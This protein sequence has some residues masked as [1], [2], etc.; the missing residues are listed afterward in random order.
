MPTYQWALYK[1]SHRSVDSTMRRRNRDHLQT[2]LRQRAS[3]RPVRALVLLVAATI[4]VACGDNVARDADPVPFRETTFAKTITLP[5]PSRATIATLDPSQL[6]CPKES[7]CLTG[8]RLLAITPDAVSA[9]GDN[10]RPILIA[11]VRPEIATSVPDSSTTRGAGVIRPAR[12]A[13]A[14]VIDWSSMR[15]IVLSAA[16][17]ADT[18]AL[19]LTPELLDVRARSDA[20]VA[21]TQGLA[22]SVYDVVPVSIQLWSGT[23][24]RALPKPIK[25]WAFAQ[26][27]GTTG[28]RPTAPLFRTAP[29]WDVSI[30]GRMAYTAGIDFD[31]G[32]FDANG[33]PLLRLIRDVERSP[34]SDS[35]VE[36]VV[37][38]TRQLIAA[39]PAL[40]RES[41]TAQLADA[42]RR[43]AA[44][45]PAV[46]TLRMLPDGTLW[47]RGA[48]APSDTMVRWTIVTPDGHLCG[49]AELPRAMTLLGGGLRGVWFREGASANATPATGGLQHFAIRCLMT[50]APHPS[51]SP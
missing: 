7:G 14:T 8:E 19:P 34:V 25:L 15:A 31:V 2:R 5:P 47:L 28:M 49:D 51:S 20:V 22:N 46:A 42:E 10:G 35:E 24:W 16:G 21:L 23:K 44:H 43:R 40:M 3:P 11:K 26:T 36:A 6:E 1:L 38:R 29:S 48:A 45:R 41:M 12:T 33:M 13:L 32:V 4:V 17:E 50:P 30:G 37:H 18:L 9:I 39:Q 27:V